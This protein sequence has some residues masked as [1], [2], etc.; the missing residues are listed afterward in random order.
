MNQY[1]K[2]SQT[3]NMDAKKDFEI[4]FVTLDK[5]L[6]I[7]KRQN[8]LFG[9]VYGVRDKGLLLSALLCL[10]QLLI[11]NIYAKIFLKWL[12]LIFST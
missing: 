12:Q 2:N 1:S 11:K 8:I 6:T 5:V 9:G 10:K 7:F 3:I 4:R